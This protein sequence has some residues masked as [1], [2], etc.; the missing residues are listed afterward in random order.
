MNAKLIKFFSLFICIEK[1][2]YIGYV[3]DVVILSLKKTV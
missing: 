1:K 3:Q 2:N